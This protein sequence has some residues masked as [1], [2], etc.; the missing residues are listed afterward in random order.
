M[1]YPSTSP[2][3]PPITESEVLVIHKEYG[4]DKEH[5][6]TDAFSYTSN[7]ENISLTHSGSFSV[8]YSQSVSKYQSTLE[9]DPHSLDISDTHTKMHSANVQQ[10]SIMTEFQASM[11]LPSLLISSFSSVKQSY[12]QIARSMAQSMAKRSIYASKSFAFSIVE[13]LSDDRGASFPLTM[14]NILPALLGSA[15]FSLPYAM[16][17][18]GYSTVIVFFLTALLSSMTSLLL[19]DSMYEISPRSKRRKRTKLDYVDIAEAA[20]GKWG[21]H[22]MNFTLVLYLFAANIVN[23][24]LLGKSMH[25]IIQPY[26]D[27]SL[28][29]VMSIFSILVLPTLYIQRLSH[30]AYLSLLSSLSIWIGGIV[31][32]V[33][34]FVGVHSWPNNAHNIPL[35][36]WNGYAL[37]VGIWLYTVLPHGIIPQV[38]A[39]MKEP[40]HFPRAIYASFCISTPI[41]VLFAII[42]ALTYGTSTAPIITNNIVWDSYPVSVV[43]NAALA[44]F[45]LLNFPLNFFVVSDAFDT[46]VLN[47]RLKSLRKGGKYHPLWISLTRPFFVAAA[48]GIGLVLPYFELI[49]GILGSFLGSLVVFVLPCVF[50]LKLKWGTLSPMGRARDIILLVI[51]SAAGCIGLYASLKG[52][53]K[54]VS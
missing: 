48:L 43:I 10:S 42:G 47:P 29:A 35:F 8:S 31:C 5:E 13:K 28:R 6:E 38:E 30:L 3:L 52:L 1:E 54:A 40:E 9:R 14:F 44:C 33:I 34:F 41:K 23:I 49:V 37:A 27:I 39:C 50:H 15:L 36:N 32:I 18:G 12:D 26:V 11:F 19:V 46:L 51:G 2:F 4:D 7:D 53:A 16:A 45:A 24:V 21:S 25:N 17:I 20:Y 22:M